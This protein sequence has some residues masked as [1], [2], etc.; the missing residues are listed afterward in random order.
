MENENRR[1]S[2]M[3]SIGLG[4]LVVGSVLAILGSAARLTPGGGDTIDRA[5]ARIFESLQTIEAEL[6][7]LGQIVQDQGRLI[8]RVEAIRIRLEELQR[9][10]GEA[11]GDGQAAIDELE[12]ILAELGAEPGG[13]V[14][15]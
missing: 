10:D 4:A 8:A 14:D 13:P 15:P 1:D 2:I 7:D 3:F 12:R 11:I 9:D 6:G 5:V